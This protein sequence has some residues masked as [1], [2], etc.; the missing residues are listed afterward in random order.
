VPEV[1]TRRM[2]PYG[3]RVAITNGMVIQF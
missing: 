3:E 1:T 2:V